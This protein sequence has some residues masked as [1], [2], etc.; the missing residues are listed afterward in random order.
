M[1]YG[2]NYDRKCLEYGMTV[3]ITDPASILARERALKVNIYPHTHTISRPQSLRSL[4][5]IGKFFF[6]TF[7]KCCV[8]V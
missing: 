5:Q 1:L 2:I 3:T 4:I 8:D 6:E 7:T